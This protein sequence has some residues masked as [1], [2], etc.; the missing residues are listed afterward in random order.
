MLTQNDTL[1]CRKHKNLKKSR[2]MTTLDLMFRLGDQSQEIPKSKQ[3]NQNHS[4]TQAKN[5]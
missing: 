2:K 4:K 1:F 5:H 3:M